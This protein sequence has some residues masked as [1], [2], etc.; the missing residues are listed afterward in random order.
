MACYAWLFEL[1]MPLPQERQGFFTIVEAKMVSYNIP[2]A[3]H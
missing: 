1:K 2:V 3:F